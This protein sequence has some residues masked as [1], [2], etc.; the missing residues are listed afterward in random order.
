M[1]W[2]DRPKLKTINWYKKVYKTIPVLSF[3]KVFCID[4][5]TAITRNN[6][7]INKGDADI[8]IRSKA[9]YKEYS[10]IN[11]RWLNFIFPAF[12]RIILL[13]GII[14]DNST[15][16]ISSYSPGRHS[17]SKRFYI[18]TTFSNYAKAQYFSSILGF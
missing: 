6:T 1:N 4:A 3:I 8:I 13:Y 18:M 10:F 7:R 12:D 2:I 5:L 15:R 16:K 9:I 11:Y 17:Q 14:M